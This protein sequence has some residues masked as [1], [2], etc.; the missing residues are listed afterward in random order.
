[1]ILVVVYI[2]D[3]ETLLNSIGAALGRDGGGIAD[4]IFA[5]NCHGSGI[6]LQL[7]ISIPLPVFSLILKRL[8]FSCS[9]GTCMREIERVKGCANRI[10]NPAAAAAENF[11]R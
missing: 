11:R 2:Y 4:I 9:G 8:A 10:Q 3:G 6:D 5:S 1:M 7:V